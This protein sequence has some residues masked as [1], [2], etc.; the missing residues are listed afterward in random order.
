MIPLLTIANN[1]KGL[2]G[3]SQPAK[4]LHDEG[5]DELSSVSTEEILRIAEWAGLEKNGRWYA[6]I[7]LP[8]R[9][10]GRG[11]DAL[12]MYKKAVELDSNDGPIR[13]GLGAT[14][15]AQDKFEDAV[16]ET[17]ASIDLHI[18]AIDR[19]EPSPDPDFSLISRL[20]T[21]RQELATYYVNIEKVDLAVQQYEIIIKEFGGCDPTATDWDELLSIVVAYYHTLTNDKRWDDATVLL[22]QLLSHPQRFSEEFVML[23][24]YIAYNEPTLL[25][26]G[27]R[28]KDQDILIAL[29]D[30]ALTSIARYGDEE[31]VPSLFYVRAMLLLRLDN[32]RADEAIRLLKAV[33]QDEEVD[34]WTKDRA[35]R[36]LAR[37]YL[38]R[39]LRAR[40]ED[41]WTDVGRYA[42]SLVN[43][44]VSEKDVDGK[45]AFGTRDCSL[46]LAAWDR[47]NGRMAR[48]KKCAE[49][50]ILLAIDM[51][52]DND[53]DNDVMAWLYMSDALLSIGDVQRAVA[54]TNMLRQSRFEE[55][56]TTDRVKEPEEVT[57]EAIDIDAQAGASRDS[58]EVTSTILDHDDNSITA[59]EDKNDLDVNAAGTDNSTPYQATPKSDSALSEPSNTSEG[60]DVAASKDQEPVTTNHG[61]PFYYC[62]GSCF[63]NIANNALMWRCSF[64]IAD[65]CDDCHNL[66]IGETMN[67]WQICGSAHEH[68]RIPGEPV[69]YPTGI[70]K[71]DGEEVQVADMMATLRKEWNYPKE[72]ATTS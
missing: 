52:S 40:E 62:D 59:I 55:S 45:P 44:V 50:A 18:A 1:A 23:Y 27:Y 10:L 61:H 39:T 15:A 31:E 38:N 7:G 19:G 11:D 58:T 34:D 56:T 5:S 33:S 9:I 54:A 64:C 17:S 72:P 49:Q 2:I 67:D 32:S 14:F 43:V 69:K 12:D 30:N 26:L 41:R 28:R 4:L 25:Q 20:M 68:V 36:E 70:I 29:N 65:F 71:I 6:R 51:L 16:R 8:L 57:D 37:Q 3:S 63:E 60:P 66:I 22:R 24:K 13:A 35:D 53:L 21:T 48:A 42:E 47:N 46:V